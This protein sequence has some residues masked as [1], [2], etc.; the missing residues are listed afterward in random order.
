MAGGREIREA[1]ENSR[2]RFPLL[3]GINFEGSQRRSYRK[4]SIAIGIHLAK[5]QSLLGPVIGNVL[6]SVLAYT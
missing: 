4:C 5:V 1:P 3:T 6:F 2:L